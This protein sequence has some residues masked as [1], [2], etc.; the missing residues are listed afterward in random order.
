MRNSILS[1]ILLFIS[2]VALA[3][4]TVEFVGKATP[5]FFEFEGT[6]GEVTG[7]AK[8]DKENKISGV[9]TVDLRKMTTGN[10]TRDGHMKDKYLEV[11][12]FP[13]ATFTLD[14]VLFS[15]G[16]H[17]AFTGSLKLHGVEKKIS[18]T[19]DFESSKATAQFKV[20]VTAFGIAVPTYT[21][22]TVGKE[23]D[24]KVTLTL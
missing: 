18:G 5:N 22:L 19:V 10:G 15:A 9:F 2:A 21:T 20:D 23:I 17:K 3:K 24:I 11:Q 16:T 7:E 6:G 8:P 1:S 13:E 12:K 4:G 14:P